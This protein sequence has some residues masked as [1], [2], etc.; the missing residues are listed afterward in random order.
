MSKSFYLST[1]AVSEKMIYGVHE[2]KEEVSGIVQPDGPGKHKNHYKVTQEEKEKVIAHTKSF[3]A[4][5]SHYCQAK[6]NKKCLEADLKIEK[7]HNLCKE[8]CFQKAFRM[9]NFPTTDIYSI[10]TST[11]LSMYPKQI[12]LKSAKK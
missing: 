11:S 8:K 7:M 4:I 12:V 9:L 10:P 5:E 6:T 3:P 2:K 1:L